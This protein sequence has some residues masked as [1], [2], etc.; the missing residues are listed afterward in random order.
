MLRWCWTRKVVKPVVV[1][2]VVVRGARKELVLAYV[3]VCV[4]RWTRCCYSK[5]SGHI[6]RRSIP[7]RSTNV[8]T[9]T[10]QIIYFKA[11]P[12]SLLLTIQ[13]S[14]AKKVNMA[15]AAQTKC[16]WLREVECGR[17]ASF[18]VCSFTWQLEKLFFTLL[19]NLI[20]LMR[21]PVE[22]KLRDAREL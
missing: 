10:K 8:T 2:A 22:F 11:R 1:V 17:F 19:Y 6:S 18:V 9:T 14:T 15:A 13:K 12:S 21:G 16:G 7:F 5:V 3:C 20:S 4:W